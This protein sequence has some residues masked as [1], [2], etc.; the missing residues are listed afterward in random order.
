MVA[1]ACKSSTGEVKAGRS[2]VQSCSHLHSEFEVDLGYLSPYL[3]SR[4]PD[5]RAQKVT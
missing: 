5:L 3:K 2:R 1:Q 4:Y